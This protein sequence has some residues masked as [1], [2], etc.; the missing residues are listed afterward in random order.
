MKDIYY[1]I[2]NLLVPHKHKF[3]K[4]RKDWFRKCTHKWCNTVKLPKDFFDE[5]I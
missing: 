4:T 1:I 5:L 3:W 2:K